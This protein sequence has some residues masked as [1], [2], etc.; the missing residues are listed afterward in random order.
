MTENSGQADAFEITPAMIEAGC[1]ALWQN[2]P[3]DVGSWV[4]VEKIFSA[5]LAYSNRAMT[6]K[7][8][9]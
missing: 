7:M 8:S 2:D 5:M 9:L 1:E 6:S 3:E 4:A